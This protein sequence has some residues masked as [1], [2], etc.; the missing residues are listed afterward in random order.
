MMEFVKV[1]ETMSAFVTPMIAALSTV[2]SAINRNKIQEV[3]ILMNGRLE[4]LLEETRRA[5]HSEGVVQG[6]EKA[7][8]A[9]ADVVKAAADV[10][11]GVATRAAEVAA[12]VA[13]RAVVTTREDDTPRD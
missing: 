9:A 2:L 4:Q 11:L 10:A 5:A 12:E 1:V 3:R 13:A 8:A 6:H 7:S